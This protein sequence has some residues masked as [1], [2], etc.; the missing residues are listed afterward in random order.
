M[1]ISILLP[2]ANGAEFL[3]E[4]LSSVVAQ[5]HTD[6]ECLVALNGEGL[7]GPAEAV[8]SA[9]QDSRIRILKI[10]TATNK[11]QALNEA[12]TKARADWIALLDVDDRWAPMKLAKQV[13]MAQQLHPQPLVIGTFARY[14]GEFHGAPTLP[15]GWIHPNQLCEVNPVINSSAMIRKEWAYWS[16]HPNCPQFMEDYY[17]WMRIM[18]DSK[19]RGGPK[20]AL[21]PIY[22]LSEHVVDHRIHKA[23]AFN[24]KDPSPEAL[25][26]WYML[27]IS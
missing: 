18:L 13:Q 20:D 11:V 19:K 16:Y 17:L 2:V 4:S 7:T 9:F 21:G 3:F 1:L 15:S 14:F 10:P 8:A 23:S 24:G 26:Q 27:A 22:I 12:V 6:W 25:Q 5:T